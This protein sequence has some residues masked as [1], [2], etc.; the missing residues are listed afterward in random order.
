MPSSTV[1]SKTTDAVKGPV[2][3]PVKTAPVKAAPVVKA[4]TNAAPVTVT[5]VDTNNR[6]KIFVAPS[7]VL[8][9]FR[10]SVVE[11]CNN[12]NPEYEDHVAE[13]N[14]LL[15]TP[16]GVAS[17]EFHDR[18]EVAKK[19]LIKVPSA[20]RETSELYA[21]MKAL[22][23]ARDND[24]EFAKVLSDQISE[25]DAECKT[26]P[27]KLAD[28][29]TPRS[30]GLITAEKDASDKKLADLKA[31]FEAELNKGK[32]GYAYQKYL[33]EMS[34][35]QKMRYRY[36]NA[37]EELI[38][39]VCGETILEMLSNGKNVMFRNGR[40]QLDIG[41]IVD[42]DTIN[43]LKMK[44]LW[45]NTNVVQHFLRTKS[46]Y[47][48]VPKKKEDGDE[49]AA[50]PVD[51]DEDD[52]HDT[53]HA[54]LFAHYIG[55]IWTYVKALD[56]NVKVHTKTD[57]DDT[58]LTLRSRSLVNAFLS[59]MLCQMI[60]SFSKS[61]NTIMKITN[62]KTV[63]PEHVYTTYEMLLVYDGFEFE[64]LRLLSKVILDPN[65]TN[66]NVIACRNTF[67]TDINAVHGCID[68]FVPK[69]KPLPK[70]A[71]EAL[72]DGEASP[73]KAPAKPRA[74]RKKA[75]TT[76]T[77]P[78]ADGDA[79]PSDKAPA[80]PRAPR[81]KT[82]DGAAEVAEAAAGAPDKVPAKPRAPRKKAE[83]AAVDAPA[84]KAP[85]KPRAKK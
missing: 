25:A 78:T 46:T 64:P 6:S 60:E 47:V 51:D 61:L 30:A 67:G 13:C 68:K 65:A 43:D 9:V 72:V 56:S 77:T 40:T 26:A 11:I 20:E 74:P 2:K 71:A 4:S 73:D 37:I 59:T 38:S 22:E 76:P 58:K 24:L 84:A 12:E 36:S 42:S 69:A 14:K 35:M 54:S 3:G 70:R 18:L 53:S 15:S 79:G 28:D 39:I 23:Q 45:V 10:K 41:D 52:E 48:S 31:K 21:P 32:A 7:R 8:R 27:K 85:V 1:V 17:K 44:N 63:K 19:A 66:A 29:G 34:R 57:D 55:S 49:A 33:N 80:K 75:E 82:P 50:A 62:V 81:K 16:S 5:V 83:A